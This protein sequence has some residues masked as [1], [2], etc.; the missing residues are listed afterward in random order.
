MQQNILAKIKGLVGI[1]NKAGYL[2]IGSDNLKG[3]N[4]KLYLLLTSD[5][6]GKT[7]EKI[8]NQLKQSTNCDIYTFCENEF[9][10]IVNI[11][12]CKIVGIKNKGISEEI[13]KYIR[14]NNIDWKRKTRRCF[15]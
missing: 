10:Q 2:V 4:K 1:A 8:T 5:S 14:S 3:Y 9:L 7:I 6:Y 13:I 15:K 12:N 11:P